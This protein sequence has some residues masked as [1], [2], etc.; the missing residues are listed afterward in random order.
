MFLTIVKYTSVVVTHKCTHTGTQRVKSDKSQ[1]LVGEKSEVSKDNSKIGSSECHTV[2][3][4]DLGWAFS[5]SRRLWSRG[6]KRDFIVLAKV[7]GEPCLPP[8]GFLV[9]VVRWL[10]QQGC[11]QREGEVGAPEKSAPL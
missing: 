1:F 4:G 11:P 2:W 5:T 10:N 3:D 6:W 9:W 8:F 7:G